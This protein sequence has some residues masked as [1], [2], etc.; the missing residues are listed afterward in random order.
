MFEIGDKV[1]YPMQG[2]GIIESVE[3]KEFAGDKQLYYIMSMPLKNMQIMIPKNK[4]SEHGIR[5]V[6]DANTLEDVFSFFNSSETDLSINH[7][8]RQRININKIKSGN[9]YEGAEVIRDLIRIGKK[10]NLG[11]EDRNT[12]NNAQQILI[13]E[14]MLVKGIEEEQA[15]EL[16]NKIIND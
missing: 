4:L 9:I 3:E 16:L 10:K 2:A 5:K 7:I 15:T 13:S 14:V 1:F 11:T 6:V 8:Q 12:L